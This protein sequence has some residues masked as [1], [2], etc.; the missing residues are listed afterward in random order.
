[1][2]NLGDPVRFYCIV[3]KKFKSTTDTPAMM[4]I[5]IA[6]WCCLHHTEDEIR[7][8]R[9][10]KVRTRLGEEI[11]MECPNCGTD[12]KLVFFIG[13]NKL[14]GV[15][16]L[17]CELSDQQRTTLHQ[18]YAPAHPAYYGELLKC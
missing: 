8:A 17:N 3:C 16:C 9:D 12:G 6:G 11:S 1:M 14:Y 7:A 18:F 10:G 13:D 4:S 5:N 15:D 2:P